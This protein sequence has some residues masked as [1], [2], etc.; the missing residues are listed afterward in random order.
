MNRKTRGRG[1]L[2][3][4]V[5]VE[6]N[7]GIVSPCIEASKVRGPTLMVRQ[8]HSNLLYQSRETKNQQKT[9]ETCTDNTPWRTNTNSPRAGTFCN[10]A[11][12]ETHSR[13]FSFS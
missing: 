12:T 6:Q 4:R 10:P 9:P 13:I 8:K 7:N 2:S 3:G 1:H 11:E 5:D